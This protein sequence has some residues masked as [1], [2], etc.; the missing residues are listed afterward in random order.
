ML[1]IVLVFAAITALFEAFL[2]LKFSSRRMLDNK[3][4]V[5]CIHIVAI[6]AN[7]AVHWG[8]I[9][10]TMTA[11]CAGL[12]SFATVPTVRYLFVLKERYATYRLRNVRN[13]YMRGR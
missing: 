3:Y 12:V 11:I 1:S 6:A 2:L 9:V 5:G 10:G 7:L 13:T 4:F 8:T